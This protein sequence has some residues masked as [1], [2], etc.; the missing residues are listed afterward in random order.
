[1]TGCVKGNEVMKTKKHQFLV[2]CSGYWA[3]LTIL[4]LVLSGH[5]IMSLHF[6]IR[7]P[8]CSLGQGW[9]SEGVSEERSP[10]QNGAQDLLACKEKI[11]S[12]CL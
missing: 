7:P 11:M 8:T 4:P 5:A 9:V 2:E 6:P 1:M 3:G 10:H 12:E